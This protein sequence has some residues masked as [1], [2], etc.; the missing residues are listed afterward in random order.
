M[1]AR[2]LELAWVASGVGGLWKQKKSRPDHA[3]DTMIRSSILG[4]S[5]P[6]SAAQEV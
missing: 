5:E 4:G 6:S 2:A 3:R 1:G